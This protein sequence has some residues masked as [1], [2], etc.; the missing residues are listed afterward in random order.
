MRNWLVVLQPLA[1][2]GDRALFLLTDLFILNRGVREGS[3]NRIEHSLQQTAHRAELLGRQAVE[4]GVSLLP[5]RSPASAW[6]PNGQAEV[7]TEYFFFG[8]SQWVS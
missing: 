7:V 3:G 1:G 4:M 6:C 5:S 2:L 8:W